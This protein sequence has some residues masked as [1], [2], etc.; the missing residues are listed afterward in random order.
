MSDDA[1]HGFGQPSLQKLDERAYL[2]GALG[3][4]AAPMA[5]SQGLDRDLHAIDL[6]AAHE[7][8]DLSGADFEID[9]GTMA[10]V[11]AAARQAVFKIPVR[12]EI[13]APGLAPEAAGDGP[14]FNH[15][16]RQLFAAFGQPLAF[17]SGIATLLLNIR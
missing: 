15:D 2:P 4:D 16:R 12:L 11:A 6:R 9:D 17:A 1:H 10:N 13:L 3:L 14:P 5:S 7:P 8:R